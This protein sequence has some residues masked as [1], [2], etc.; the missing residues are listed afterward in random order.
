MDVLTL[1]GNEDGSPPAP[2]CFSGVFG[3]ACC[4]EYQA[5]WRA[6]CEGAAADKEAR[7]LSEHK[8]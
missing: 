2:R 5:V 8:A 7:L 6:R 3:G 1:A 4:L